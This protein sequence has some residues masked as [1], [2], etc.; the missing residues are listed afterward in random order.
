MTNKHRVVFGFLVTPGLL[1]AT[2]CGSD[3]DHKPGGSIAVQISGEEAAT[4]GFLF[5]TGSEVTFADGWEMHF[6]HVL[7]TVDNVTLSNNPNRSPSDQSQTDAAVARAKGPW[8]VDLAVEGSAVGAGGEGRATPVTT[9]TNQNLAG[10]KAFAAD[11]QYA[12]GYDIIAATDTAIK[13]NFAGDAEAEAA[14][15]TMVSK[16]YAVMYVGTATFK[17]GADCQSSDAEYDFSQIPSEVAFELGYATPTAYINSKTRKIRAIPSPA[18]S[19]RAASPCCRTKRRFAQMTLHMEH[20]WFSSTVHD[21]DIYFDQMAA[22]LV[23][24]QAARCSRWTTSSDSIR[25][26][27]GRCGRPATVGACA[28]TQRSRAG[29]AGSTPATS[30]SILP[31]IPRRLCATTVTT[32]TTCRARRATSTA[33]RGSVTSDATTPPRAEARQRPERNES[34]SSAAFGVLRVDSERGYAR[35]VGDEV[36][37]RR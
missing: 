25:C 20:P 30:R 11:E 35:F 15:A 3:D 1:F 33:V 9:I 12:F 32:W 2:G 26:V 34:R 18:R 37:Q 28:R 6:S 8:A 27:H 5:P 36:A 10:G 19:T 7:V 17:G 13:L 4:D 23:A 31:A 21:S 14:Y 29:S 16:G 22:P 24:N